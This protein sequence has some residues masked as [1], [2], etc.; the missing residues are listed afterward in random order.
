MKKILLTLLATVTSMGSLIAQDLITTRDGK[1]IQAKIIEVT[2]DEIKYKKWN[3][4]EGPMFTMKKSEVLI[5]RYQNGENEVF[6]NEPQR[7]NQSAYNTYG[8]TPN[9]DQIHDRMFFSEYKDLYDPSFYRPEY[10]DPYSPGWCGFASFLIPGLGQSIAGEWGRGL[11]FFG[12]HYGAGLLG[13]VVVPSI[14]DWDDDYEYVMLAG[15][16]V[17]LAIDI[18]SI[19]DASK[20]AKI[21]NMYV[22]DVRRMQ[23]SL[24]LSVS[25]SLMFAPEPVAGVNTPVAG[26]SLS[27]K[28]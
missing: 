5:V 1:D 16:V 6:A 8:N 19:V 25:P 12:A 13:F 23:S 11:A 14:M 26:L 7:K 21:K 4:Q 17:M 9:K 28:F 27:L 10:G 24:S 2:S 22:Q 3:N 20:V 15:A 18:W